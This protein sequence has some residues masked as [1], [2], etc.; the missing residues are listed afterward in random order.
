M[1]EQSTEPAP[2]PDRLAAALRTTVGALVR[3]TRSSDRL[4][5]IP[6][7][8]LDLLDRRG[9]MT[10]AELAASRGVRHQTMAATV[11]ELAEAGFLAAGPDPADARKRILALTSAGVHAVEADRRD[12]I[13]V[14]A[15]AIGAGLDEDERR[16]LARALP[17]LERIAAEIA[18]SGSGAD[19]GPV[20]GAW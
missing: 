12:R 2:S 20:T 4:A 19:R 3:A 1:P 18:R 5:T 14:L 8:V 10:T 16:T 11:K 15:R 17:V 13:G 9:P 6:A 7:G